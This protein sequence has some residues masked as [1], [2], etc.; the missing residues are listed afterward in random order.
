MENIDK[1]YNTDC[2]QC[3]Y[4]GKNYCSPTK[5]ADC[6]NFN[7][8]EKSCGCLADYK[9]DT[10]C[11]YFLKQNNLTEIQETV[12]SV[13]KGAN[14]ILARDISALTGLSDRQIRY[15][16]HDL[17]L[18]GYPIC[19]GNYGYK[20]DKTCIADTIKRLKNSIREQELALNALTKM[21]EGKL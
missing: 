2:K 16:V 20:F 19:S 3:T 14:F 1:F 10:H 11:P 21:L 7:E 12:L 15:I 6:N 18:Q 8:T 5:C 9:D 13:I 4:S 17:R